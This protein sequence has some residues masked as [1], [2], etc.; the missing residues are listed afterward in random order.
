ML[1]SMTAALES[2]FPYKLA[3]YAMQNDMDEERFY[4]EEK[5]PYRSPFQRDRDRII[6]S[7]AF[8]RLAYKTQV[9]VYSEGDIYRNRLTHSLEVAQISRSVSFALGLNQDFAEALAL[10]H[11]LGHPPFAHAGQEA[12]DTLM[13]GQGGFEHNCQ[14]LRQLTK[15]ETRY[16]DFPGLNLTRAVLKGMMKRPVVYNCDHELIKL[17]EERRKSPPA[18][19]A[20]LVDICDRIAYLHHD[21]EDGLDAGILERQKLAELAHW[22]KAWEE[23][24]EKKAK[25]FEEAREAT[26]IRSVIRHMLN[27]SIRDLIDNSLKNLRERDSKQDSSDPICLSPLYQSHLNQL[28]KYLYKHFYRSVRVTH[29]STNGAKIIESLFNCF[30]QSPGQMPEHYQ[31]WIAKEGLDRTVADYIAGMTDRFAGKIHDKIL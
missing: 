11:D 27:M 8:R 17:A 7:K 10:A 3:P 6:H 23:L 9:F 20:H 12:L 28:H 16:L 1:F 13:Q 31:D 30:L 29:M 22:E 15:L 21:L 5:N 14:G 24:K 26:R 18:L 4:P 2:L 25:K 19:E